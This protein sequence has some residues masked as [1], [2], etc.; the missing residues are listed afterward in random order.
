MSLTHLLYPSGQVEWSEADHH[1]PYI[2][3]ASAFWGHNECEFQDSF[4]LDQG[5]VRY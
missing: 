1:R 3:D 5:S 2:Y 4:C